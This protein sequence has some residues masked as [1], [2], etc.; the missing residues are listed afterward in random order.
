MKTKKNISKREVAIYEDF[1]FL[2]MSLD[3]NV[4]QS[5]L[6]VCCLNYASMGIKYFQVMRVVLNQCICPTS[7]Q[8]GNLITIKLMLIILS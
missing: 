1:F 6:E 7:S 8:W 4:H 2:I 3:V 5:I